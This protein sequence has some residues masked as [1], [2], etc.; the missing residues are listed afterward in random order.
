MHL[1][2]QGFQRRF[3]SVAAFSNACSIQARSLIRLMLT[4]NSCLTVVGLSFV[5]FRRD[6]PPHLGISVFMAFFCSSC[7]IFPRHQSS[8]AKLVVVRSCSS[9]D[10][11]CS[12]S[13]EPT[14]VARSAASSPTSSSSSPPASSQSTALTSN[15]RCT[16]ST[17]NRSGVH[18]L[19]SDPSQL[20]SATRPEASLKIPHQPLPFFKTI[21]ILTTLMAST[22]SAPDPNDASS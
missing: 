14:Q 8:R 16:A 3:G 2:G 13:A 11:R 9:P 22:P 10:Y 20:Q 21:M 17:P 18:N 15:F 12:T 1:I 19:L 7:C 6:A 4:A 5:W